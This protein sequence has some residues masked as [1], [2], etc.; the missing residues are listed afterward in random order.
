MSFSP[1][2]ILI[3]APVVPLLRGLPKPVRVYVAGPLIRMRFLRRVTHTMTTPVVAW[4]TMNVVFLAWHVPGAYNFALEN[5]G[6]HVVEHI[7]FLG[8]SLLF[9]YPLIRPW[10]AKPQYPGW[11]MILY[12]LSADLVN[13]ALSAFLAFCDKPVYTFYLVHPNPFGIAPLA[14]QNAGA[15]VMWVLG[16]TIFLPPALYITVR[17]LQQEGTRRPAARRA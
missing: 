13:T 17:M 9:W 12:L 3:G 4:F 6:W 14:D 16:S 5:E 8:S 15:A 11:F 1:P 7:C 10:P 2:L